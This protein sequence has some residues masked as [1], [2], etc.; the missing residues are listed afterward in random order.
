MA[1]A[2]EWSDGAK[3][4]NKSSGSPMPYPNKQKKLARAAAL[5]IALALLLVVSAASV[6]AQVIWKGDMEEGSLS[7]WYL[8]GGGGL[9]NSGYYSA[10]A[11]AARA[12]SGRYCLR[13]Q[14]TAPPESGVRAFRWR[15]PRVNRSLYYSAWFY[16]PVQYT[17]TG[18]PYRYWNIFQF[19]SR[20]TSGRNDPLWAFYLEPS[21][22]QLKVYA[23]WGW[24]GTV[25]SGPFMYSNVSGKVYHQSI[26]TI[27]VG[28]WVH[29]EC[30]LRQ[31]KDFDGR[32]VFWQNGVQLFDFQ[33]IRT[34][35]YNPNYNSWYAS[36]EWSV[37]NM[38]DGLTPKPSTLYIDDA[39]ISKTRTWVSNDSNS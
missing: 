34:S 24:G 15:E 36:N 37:D 20:S 38:S 1:A 28:R 22:T 11:S 16:F 3:V 33:N 17:I 32:L 12:H 29:L 21:G 26:A 7:D 13:A 30:F 9:F 35:Y 19:K 14:I 10:T 39:V 4:L 6:S 2:C 8:S 25:V 5:R 18:G 27:P 31:S 23:G